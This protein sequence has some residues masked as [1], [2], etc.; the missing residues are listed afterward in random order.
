[1]PEISK[2]LNEEDNLSYYEGTA[3]IKYVFIKSMQNAKK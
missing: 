1:M 3:I 2:T